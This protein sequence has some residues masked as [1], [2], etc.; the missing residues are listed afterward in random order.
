MKPS[1]YWKRQCRATF[2]VDEVGVA[3]L[4]MMGEETVMW[5]DFPHPDGVWPDSQDYISKQFGHLP[6]RVREKIVCENAREFYGSRIR[7]R[8]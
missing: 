8:G 5:V 6:K 3:L 4:E 2:Q 7:E 1:D